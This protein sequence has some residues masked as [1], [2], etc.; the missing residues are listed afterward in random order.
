MSLRF[1]IPIS[2]RSLGR[3]FHVVPDDETERD[4]SDPPPPIDYRPFFDAGHQVARW[5]LDVA[6]SRTG[7]PHDRAAIDRVQRALTVAVASSAPACARPEISEE[8]LLTVAGILITTF[9]AD[10]GV[11]GLGVFAGSI[12]DAADGDL[13]LVRAALTH[14]AASQ[15]AATVERAR[16]RTPKRRLVMPVI[17][18]RRPRIVDEDAFA[19]VAST[20]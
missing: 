2:L 6:R 8:D 11:P 16:G 5:L 19:D 3:G 12:Y 18:R 4:P 14:M 13:E 9:E 15:A 1:S 7:D 10:L 20:R 17:V